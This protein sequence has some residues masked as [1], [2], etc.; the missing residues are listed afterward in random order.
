LPPHPIPLPRVRRR[1]EGE[2]YGIILT[3]K[4]SGVKGILERILERAG[5]KILFN[6]KFKKIRTFERVD[7]T[8]KFL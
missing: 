4:E 3:L 6:Q 1:G 8:L 5:I 2:W 7:G